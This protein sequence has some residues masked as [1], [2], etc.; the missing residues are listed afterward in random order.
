LFD[1]EVVIKAGGY[2]TKTVG[3]DME[4]VLRMRRYMAE[5]GEKY[6]VKYIPDPLCWTEVPSDF[7]SLRKQRTRWTRGLVESLWAHRKMFLRK[8]YGPLGMLGYPYWFFFEWMAPLIAFAGMVYT[9]ILLFMNALNWPF[10]LLLYA[11]VYTFAVSLS[12]WAVLFEEVTFHKYKRRRD[13]LRLV[14]SA[15]VEPFF[16]PMHTLFAVVGNIEALH[17]KKG[18]GNPH[19]KGF[20]KK[21]KSTGTVTP[22]ATVQNSIRRAKDSQSL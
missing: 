6:E 12:V 11:F 15:F 2:S 4:L 14:A 21:K 13:V 17:G 8:K 1:R 7:R 3:E 22:S 5:K 20:K 19:R 9:V 16:Y 10:F 18:W